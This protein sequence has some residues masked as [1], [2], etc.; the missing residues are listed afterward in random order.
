MAQIAFDTSAIRETQTL[1]RTDES[2]GDDILDL[3]GAAGTTA[4][5]DLIGDIL[6]LDASEAE[7]L[8]ARLGGAGATTGS[9][10]GT[11]T[12]FM[13]A[14]EEVFQDG[15]PK[16][17]PDPDNKP[18]DIVEAL[19]EQG[20]IKDAPVAD[21]TQKDSGGYGEVDPGTIEANGEADRNSALLQDW[22]S[23]LA[24]REVANGG[25]DSN[26]EL[27]I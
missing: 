17:A 13:T 11:G 15:D 21:G 26:V 2:A 20:Y 23:L 22:I 19:K 8:I 14:G 25:F 18:K 16:D 9:G 3:P 5:D 4:K 24:D 1:G 10:T 7:A 6:S 12:V 27:W